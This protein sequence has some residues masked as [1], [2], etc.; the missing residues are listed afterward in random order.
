M[1][2]IN[3]TKVFALILVVLSS[4]SYFYFLINKNDIG[5]ITSGTFML[6]SFWGYA[7]ED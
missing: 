3:K 5:I 4:I 7:F 1:K 2:T 6:I